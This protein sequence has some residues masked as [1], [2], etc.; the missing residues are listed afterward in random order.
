MEYTNFAGGYTTHL[1]TCSTALC[2]SVGFLSSPM[3]L[4]ATI[5]LVILC[6]EKKFM[7]QQYLGYL[8]WKT[9]LGPSHGMIHRGWADTPNLLETTKFT[10]KYIAK[11]HAL[12]CI[13]NFIATSFSFFYINAL[14]MLES[15]ADGMSSLYKLFASFLS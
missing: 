13:A 3:E 7:S 12:E 14:R 9:T 11:I 2:A 6:S 1:Y 10:L 5:G 4:Y 8:C 15:L